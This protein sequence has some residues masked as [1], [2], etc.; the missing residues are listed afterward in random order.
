MRTVVDGR[1]RVYRTV[2]AGATWR[3]LENGLPQSAWVT[4]LRE[5]LVN[6]ALDPCGLYLGTST[7]HLFASRD[8]GESWSMLAAFLPGIL[9]VRPFTV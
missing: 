7:G 6:D 8:R 4:V 1:L 2:D 9:C 3:P 5:G